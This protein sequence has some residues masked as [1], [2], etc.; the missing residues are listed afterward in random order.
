MGKT[1][2]IQDTA[3]KYYSSRAE[4]FNNEVGAA[5]MEREFLGGRVYTDV[6]SRPGF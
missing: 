5:E 2:N 1:V 3:S 6:G 4:D